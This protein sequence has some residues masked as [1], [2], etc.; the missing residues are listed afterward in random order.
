MEEGGDDVIWTQPSVK[1]NMSDEDV[2]DDT[3]LVKA[4]DKA[5]AQLREES[6][7]ENEN[8]NENTMACD[9]TAGSSGQSCQLYS[10]KKTKKKNRKQR[11]NRKKWRVGE[12][13]LAL[14]QDGLYYEASVTA[15]NHD[16]CTAVVKFSYYGNEENV[17]YDKLL[18][19]HN[20]QR[21]CVGNRQSKDDATTSLNT[22]Q[23]TN[24]DEFNEL[25]KKHCPNEKRYVSEI[26]SLL[27]T[28]NGTYE[29]V[30]I[31]SIT[32]NEVCFVTLIN[33]N[34]KQ[35]V[36]L[37]D[38]YDNVPI[39]D[40]NTMTN[41]R[42]SPCDDADVHLPPPLC[43]PDDMIGAPILPPPPPYL[44]KF[45]P[46]SNKTFS[47]RQFA[48]IRPPHFPPLPNLS[49]MDGEKEEALSN[50]LMSWYMSGYHMGYYQGLQRSDNGNPTTVGGRKGK[51]KRKR[52]D[53]I[54]TD[55]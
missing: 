33:T 23:S 24:D 54:Y 35:E 11:N 39:T 12:S 14:Y 21:M 48:N 22:S 7:Q 5:I 44:P 51:N 46:Q 28:K 53:R 34:V 43:I 2:W 45:L 13:C 49:D 32:S 1:M 8:E 37:S 9:N 3:A 25:E 4:Y 10:G 47:N 16:T 6:A 38:L 18:L 27:D 55:L 30:V 41:E 29:K 36:K 52:N 20:K 50:M 17:S 40:S 19:M 26:C 15:V 42:D 31:N